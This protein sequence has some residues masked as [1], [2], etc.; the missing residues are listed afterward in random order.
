MERKVK[1]HLICSTC[2]EPISKD[3]GDGIFIWGYNTN[4]HPFRLVHKG[5]CDKW[6]FDDDKGYCLSMEVGTLMEKVNRKGT[7]KE[8]RNSIL[9]MKKV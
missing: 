1:N 6:I 7:S 3:G 8:L 4:T 2:V 9:N 5:A